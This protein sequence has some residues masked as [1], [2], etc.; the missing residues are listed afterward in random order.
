MSLIPSRDC[1][2]PERSFFLAVRAGAPL[3][4]ASLAATAFRNWQRWCGGA[5]DTKTVTFWIVIQW[6]N[7]IV[8]KSLSLEL[9]RS[10]FKETKMEKSHVNLTAAL[11]IVPGP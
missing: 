8:S 7:E 4:P 6:C 5:L 1:G 10:T 11:T 9:C 2:S 3:P